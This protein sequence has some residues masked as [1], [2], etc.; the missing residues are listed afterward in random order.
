MRKFAV[1]ALTVLLLL[2]CSDSEDVRPMIG[3]YVHYDDNGA[4]AVCYRSDDTF[5]YIE[6]IAYTDACLIEGTWSV[7]L[8]QYN[9]KTARGTLSMVVDEVPSGFSGLLL[10]EG[11]NSMEFYWYTQDESPV[12]TWI[13]NETD[14]SKNYTFYYSGD[15]SALDSIV[16]EWS[17]TV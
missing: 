14:S 15:E 17:E 2:S 7:D 8:D 1:I 13:Y 3:T 6:S 12:L 10:S 11:R 16:S 5:S 9:F 4:A